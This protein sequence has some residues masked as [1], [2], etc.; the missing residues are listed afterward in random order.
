M[1]FSIIQKSQLEGGL[2]LDAEYYQ[3]EFLNLFSQIKKFKNN[4]LKGIAMIL[5][6]LTPKE[7]GDFEIPIIRSGD[8]SFG[9]LSE[10]LLKAR[11][12]NI[13]YVKNKDIL[14]SSIGLG[15]IGKVNIFISDNNK[16]GIVSEVTIIR[17]SKINPF[18]IWTFLLSKFGQ[19]QINREITRATG[20]LHLNTSNVENII[21][22]IIPQR[23]IFEK[24]YFRAENLFKDSKKYY[25]QAENLLLKEL[26]LE[27]FE[28][29]E[30]LFSIINL[31]DC[32]KANRIDAEYFQP[33]YKNIELKITNS[34]Y[35][36]LG[37][38]IKNYSTGY[39]FSSNNYQEQGIP[40]IRINNIKKGII[41]LNETVFLT[42]DDFKMSPKDI[43][44]PGDIVLSMSGTIG[45]SALI[46]KN[47]PE[48]AVNQRI[49]KFTPRNIDSDFLVLFLNSM[50]GSY[51][52]RRIGTGGVQT[53]ISYG[54]IKNIL[55][56]ILPKST[57]EKIAELVRKSHEAR[58]KS[59]ELL[60]RAK[61]GVEN[62]IER[63]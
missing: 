1:T 53:N 51:Q 62:L 63:G 56:P 12:E 31:S 54:D 16:I 29:E 52:L 35:K 18:Y 11:D 39:P 40:L 9:F 22:P 28:S 24:I 59:K 37:D 23:D 27:N 14:I 26:G 32:Q 58:R 47:I 50:A 41:D 13:F 48:C 38:F 57:Q 6:G 30:K 7:Y 34:K 8:L 25:Q 42:N 49:L 3:P 46:P 2:R 60:E 43:A 45:L 5:R 19:F 55:I 36:K 17:D 61:R 44:K 33:K 21:I 10:D 15:S 4:K 20:Q